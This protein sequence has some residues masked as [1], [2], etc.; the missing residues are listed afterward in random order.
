MQTGAH[1]ADVQTNVQTPSD[2]KLTPRHH[3]LMVALL[4][5]PVS[6]EEVDAIVGAS[7]GPDEVSRARRRFG[8]VIPCER[9]TGRDRDGH[10][11]EFGVYSL[12]RADRAKARKLVHG[13]AAA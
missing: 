9:M 12:T 6:R 1:C 11:V 3:R 13:R 2:A 7:N 4:A 8:L 10:R 5:G